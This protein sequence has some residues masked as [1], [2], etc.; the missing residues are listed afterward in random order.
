[1]V[2]IGRIDIA[3]DISLLSSN[4]VMPREGHLEAA[5]HDMSYLHLK[6]L[7]SLVFDPKYP[8]LYVCDFDQYDWTTHYG[9]VKEAVTS[10]AP[11]TLGR[12]VVLRTMINSDHASDK[13]TRRSRTGYFI[14]LYQVLIGWLFK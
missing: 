6:H 14:W 2:K 5:I 13:M 8:T 12:S 9:G 7:S 4:L 10:N 3:T 11:E 1:M